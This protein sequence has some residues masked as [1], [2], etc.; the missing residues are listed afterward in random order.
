M[1]IRDWRRFIQNKKVTIILGQAGEEVVLVGSKAG[2]LRGHHIV[3]S[4]MVDL[5]KTKWGFTALDEADVPVK[6]LTH[7]DHA[8][9][10][11]SSLHNKM[12]YV[13]EDGRTAGKTRLHPSNLNAFE[14]PEEMMDA[15][16]A[17]Y[18]TSGYGDLA[19]VTRACCKKNGVPFT[20]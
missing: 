13:S 17:F 14:Q 19:K 10:G 5:L 8:G 20:Q 11:S 2:I 15:L 16:I 12:W 1:K 7:A 4:S 6:V 3:E 9:A 18:E